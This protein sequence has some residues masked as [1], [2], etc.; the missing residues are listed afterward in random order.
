MFRQTQQVNRCFSLIVR[1]STSLLS[2]AVV[3]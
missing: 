2:P 1:I 3:N